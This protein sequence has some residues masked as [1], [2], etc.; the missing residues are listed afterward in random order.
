MG[1]LS[2]FKET[3]DIYFRKKFFL[4]FL[5]LITVAISALTCKRSNDNTRNT[6]DKI[7]QE[8]KSRVDVRDGIFMESLAFF[9]LSIDITETGSRIF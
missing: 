6:R 4:F 2:V 8:E 9:F 5:F 3:N 7:L 1:C